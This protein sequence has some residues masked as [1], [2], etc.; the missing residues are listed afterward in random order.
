MIRRNYPKL[1]I[2]TLL[3]FLL[4]FTLLAAQ[5][6]E[7]TK[8]RALVKE[9]LNEY[10]LDDSEKS[11]N[12]YTEYNNLN[13]D[14]EFRIDLTMSEINEINEPQILVEKSKE[15]AYTIISEIAKSVLLNQIKE[16]CNYQNI[17][18][19][20]QHKTKD[21]KYIKNTFSINVISLSSISDNMNKTGFYRILKEQ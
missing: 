6:T 5:N 2:F 9:T 4:N 18:L 8:Y 11:F 7:I 10:Y 13:L 19:N 20:F 14:L 21:Y 12:A 17:I 16:D 1:L 15:M 3:I